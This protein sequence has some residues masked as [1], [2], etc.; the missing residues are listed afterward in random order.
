MIIPEEILVGASDQR[1][2]SSDNSGEDDNEGD[3]R[4]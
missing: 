4:D 1:N 3:Q 2:D